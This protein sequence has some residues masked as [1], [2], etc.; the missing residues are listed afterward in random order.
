MICPAIVPAVEI[1]TLSVLSA[2]ITLKRRRC[3]MTFMSEFSLCPACMMEFE[4]IVEVTNIAHTA[5]YCP[6]CGMMRYWY[7]DYSQFISSADSSWPRY[8]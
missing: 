6:K 3:L 7:K 5:G 2:G 1:N 8:R 4:R